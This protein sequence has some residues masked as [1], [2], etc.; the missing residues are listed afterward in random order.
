MGKKDMARD[1]EVTVNDLVEEKPEEKPVTI[2]PSVPEELSYT[3]REIVEHY[4]HYR[5]LLTVLL[6]DNKRYTVRE[7]NE[8]LSRKVS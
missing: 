1:D 7:V 6:D 8:I 4:S 5:D 3:K 2:K